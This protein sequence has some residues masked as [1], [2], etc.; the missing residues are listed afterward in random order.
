MKFEGN[1]RFSTNIAAV[2]DNSHTLRLLMYFRAQGKK[3][4]IGVNSPTAS[5]I[6]FNF[7]NLLPERGAKY[8]LEVTQ[9]TKSHLVLNSN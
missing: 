5:V 4:E 2:Q 7:L 8:H 1:T 9:K 3:R 6:G